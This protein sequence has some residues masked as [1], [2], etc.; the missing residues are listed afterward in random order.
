MLE[1]MNE[2]ETEVKIYMNICSLNDFFEK[3]TIFD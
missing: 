1:N 2:G 3:I